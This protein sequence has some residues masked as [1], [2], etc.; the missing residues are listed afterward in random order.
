MLTNDIAVITD[1]DCRIPQNIAVHRVAFQNG[2]DDHLLV[3]NLISGWGNTSLAE[4]QAGRN[5]DCAALHSNKSIAHHVVCF[6]E[7]LQKHC[8]GARLCALSELAPLPLPRTESK[9]LHTCKIASVGTTAVNDGDKQEQTFHCC[10][11]HRYEQVAYHV[12]RLLQA[13]HVDLCLRTKF[14]DLRDTSMQRLQPMEATAF[15]L[16]FKVCLL[17]RTSGQFLHAQRLW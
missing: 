10:L 9:G 16:E 12:P 5:R 6:G 3:C 11:L 1:H 7:L 13:Q 2:T 4:Q 17:I 14:N 15:M 8:R